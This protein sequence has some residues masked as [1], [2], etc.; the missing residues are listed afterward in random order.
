MNVIS[1]E[2]FVGLILGGV[3]ALVAF[4]WS[5][6]FGTGLA[7]GFI[8]GLTVLVIV[9]LASCVGATLP[10]IAR[11]LGLDPA[12]ASAPMVTTVADASG[13]FV[14]FLIARTV[15]DF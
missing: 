6:I 1:R 5:Q 15:L 9:V 7:I 13:L 10:I 4:F 11:K 8:V 2:S 14:Y 12:V 3:M